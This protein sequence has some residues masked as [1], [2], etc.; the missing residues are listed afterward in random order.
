MERFKRFVKRVRE[1]AQ[2]PLVVKCL[3]E[4]VADWQSAG[5]FILIKPRA[6]SFDFILYR[7]EPIPLSLDFKDRFICQITIVSEESMNE[8][9]VPVYQRMKTMEC[10]LVWKGLIGR[11]PTFKASKSLEALSRR[12]EGLAFNPML[13]KAI[14]SDESI[15]H[16]IS[17]IKPGE[18]S[19]QL[20]SMSDVDAY[21]AVTPEMT[22]A[23]QA[24]Y[25]KEPKDI[26]WY[27]NLTTMLTRG[28]S[29]A[30][31][32][33]EVYDLLENIA[34]IVRKIAENIRHSEA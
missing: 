1:E 30:R 17:R 18:L 13:A 23:I 33:N 26:V 32:V 29:Y 15:I 11:K 6:A 34:R 9:Y 22:Y 31:K 19:I 16:L 10:E 20:K 28:P 4:R 25:F 12:I 14:A 7:R 5:G 2:I 21:F 24:T 8:K 27:V 3:G